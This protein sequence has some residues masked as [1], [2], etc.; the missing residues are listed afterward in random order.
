MQPNNNTNNGS[1]N[2]CDAGA[3]EQVD[4][5]SQ[6]QALRQMSHRLLVDAVIQ[7]YTAKIKRFLQAKISS[8]A[9]R[10]DLFQVICFK[11]AQSKNLDT[12]EQLESYVTKIAVNVVTDKYRNDARYNEHNI[13]LDGELVLV[14]N[15]LDP[16]QWCEGEQ[17]VQGIVNKMEKLSPRCRQAVL[18]RRVS[19][20]SPKIIAQTMGV[21]V[22]M[23]EKYITRGNQVIQYGELTAA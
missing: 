13:T 6:L 9:D 17:T 11:I 10:D 8:S 12:V 1:D 2:R 19:G 5:L 4:Y 15:A 20:L 22:S 7:Q 3:S 23:V 21:S 18:M 16:E 14:D